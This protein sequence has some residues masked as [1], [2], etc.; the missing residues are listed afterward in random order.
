M[1][2]IHGVYHW[3][4][5]R[6]AYRSDYC[7][8]CEA[9]CIA[10]QMR[11]FD[12]G[13]LFFVPVLPLGYRKRWHCATCGN[14]P[15]ERVKTARRTLV[16]GAVVAALFGIIACMVPIEGGDDAMGMWIM[17]LMCLGG[18]AWLV[19]LIRTQ[20]DDGP[21]LKTELLRVRPLEG[22]QCRYCSGT[23]ESTVI[24][25]GWR[26]RRCLSCGVCRHDPLPK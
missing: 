21:D 24:E 2:L 12:A 17:R 8:S 23:L 10:E 26:L 3:G 4:G 16:V 5:K 25:K 18:F 14:N 15:H 1:F 22:G 11:T 19:Y 6:I 13:H 20:K 7:L 9:P